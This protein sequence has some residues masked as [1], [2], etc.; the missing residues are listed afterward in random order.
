MTANVNAI[1]KS[2]LW[3]DPNTVREYL[4]YMSLH[5]LK[6]KGKT[7]CNQTKQSNQTQ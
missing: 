4:Q 7:S 2:S 6:T 3:K 5:I 1:A